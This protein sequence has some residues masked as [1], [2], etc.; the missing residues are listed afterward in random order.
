MH[1]YTKYPGTPSARRKARFPWPCFPPRTSG[2]VCVGGV[3]GDPILSG[4]SHTRILWDPGSEVWMRVREAGPLL[5][6]AF[7]PPQKSEVMG[8]LGRRF[9]MGQA[10]F[11]SLKPAPRSRRALGSLPARSGGPGAA[12]RRRGQPGGTS[13]IPPPRRSV[14]GRERKE[15]PLSA[16]HTHTHTRLQKLWPPLPPLQRGTDGS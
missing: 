13:G 16:T 9:L 15:L 4:R 10:A 1:A 3:P 12:P 5:M 2:S 14:A 6:E 7:F 11:C 8:V